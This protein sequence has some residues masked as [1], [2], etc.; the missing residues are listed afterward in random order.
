[1]VFDFAIDI[2]RAA[3]RPHEI[4]LTSE[5]IEFDLR[6]RLVESLLDASEVGACILHRDV[7]DRGALVIQGHR[8]HVVITVVGEIIGLVP[9]RGVG[10]EDVVDFL[11]RPLGIV[12]AQRGVSFWIISGHV[13]T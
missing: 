6:H 9:L 3:A 4:E 13:I 7:Q 11:Q 2:A 10:V 8:G 1:M 12:L 5:R